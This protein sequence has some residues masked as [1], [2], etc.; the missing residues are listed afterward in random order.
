MPRK[1]PENEEKT[2]SYI[3]R[4]LKATITYWAP[5]APDGFGGFSFGAPST[6]KA[7]WEDRTENFVDDQGQEKISHARVYVDTDLSVDGYLFEGISSS[8]DPRTVDGAI[9]VK[10]FRRIPNLRHTEFERRV[11]L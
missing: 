8:T 4:N 7:R 5:G 2:I 11:L 10:D 9:E 3:T 1:H 6:V